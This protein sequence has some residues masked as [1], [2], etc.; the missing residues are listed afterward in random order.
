MN[1]IKHLNAAFREIYSDDRLHSGHIGLYMALFI[2]WNL[3]RFADGFYANRIEIMKMAKIGSRTTYHR[4]IKELAEW[5]YIEYLPTQDPN[6]KTMVRVYHIRTSSST[7]M[8]HSGTLM[9]RYCPKNVLPTLYNKQNKQYKLSE[10]GKPKNEFEVIDFFKGKNWPAV[11]AKKFYNH[12]QGVGWK[13]GGK[14]QIA[15]WT[16]IAGNWMLKAD[17]IKRSSPLRIVSKNRD[18]LMT[19]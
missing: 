12:Y 7:D 9:E 13:I 4:L 3:H 14:T 18:H 15:D 19:S 1:Y 11:E 16:A 8:V 10:K 17:E 5:E 2:Y 6:R